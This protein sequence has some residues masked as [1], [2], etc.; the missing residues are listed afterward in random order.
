MRRRSA[1]KDRMRKKNNWKVSRRAPKRE[2]MILPSSLRK[3]RR[4][5]WRKTSTFC[6]LAEGEKASEK[7]AGRKQ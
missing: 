4:R 3:D 6:V 7:I 5:H 1:E 2:G